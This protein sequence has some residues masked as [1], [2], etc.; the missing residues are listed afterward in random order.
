[1][2][3]ATRTDI[4]LAGLS[5]LT[6]CAS[7]PRERGY[8]ETAALVDARTG[9]AANLPQEAV[10]PVTR[11]PVPREPLDI[12]QAVR[13]A[14]ERNPRVREAY[15]R[16]GVGRADLEEARRIA[17]PTFGYAYLDAR[18]DGSQITRSVSVGLADLLLLPARKRFAEGELE[19]LQAS[20]AADL[21]DL[22]AQVEAAWYENVSARQVA[23][24][25]D[26]VARAAEHS[27]ELAQRFFRAGNIDRLQLE[28]ELAAAAQARID[29]VRAQ[30]DA[31][32]ARGTLAGLLSLPLTS[33]WRTTERLAE[34]PA[35]STDADAIVRQALDQRL[36][37][38]AARQEVA[39]LEDALGITRRWRWLG[40]IDVGYE[41]ESEI[42]G[43]VLRGPSLS[44]QLPIF[45]Q[46]QGAVA[47]ARADLDAARARLDALALAVS[48]DASLGLERLAVTREIAERYRTALVPHREAIVA[49]SQEQVNFML[50]GV[51][52]LIVAKQD[53]YDAYQAYLE[54]VRDYW[55]ARS[56]LR[57]LAGGRLPDD[58]TAL[59]PT[60][61]VE[62]ILPSP[63]RSHDSGH[64]N[65]DDEAEQSDSAPPDEH[66]H[67]GDAP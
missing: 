21:V 15:A 22:A 28:R 32:R 20:V 52:E 12:E 37:L 44:L 63:Q 54:A 41:R 39:L 33:P 25:R 23:T 10:E 51:F 19:R 50:I 49:R 65:A 16:L 24:M 58:G 64:D 48:N 9:R 13:L 36:D 34:P 11:A 43:T 18:G 67:H 14:F 45:N 2:L 27:A 38:A 17:N 31:L 61:G 55:V 6:G 66:R 47:R 53:E 42:D 29:A 40:A 56:D 26:V 46:S 5:V 3:T 1:M 59:E 57:R 4:A 30:A 60:I 62:S 7:L 8:A 35:V